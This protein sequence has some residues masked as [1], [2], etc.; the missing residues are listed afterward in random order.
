MVKLVTTRIS[1]AQ[2]KER[3]YPLAVL[4]IY[5]YCKRILDL[6]CSWTPSKKTV[7]IMVNLKMIQSCVF[8]VPIINN[9][10]YVITKSVKFYGAY[11]SNNILHVTSSICACPVNS[12]SHQ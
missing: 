3:N 2:A 8:D 9:Y 12:H 10:I 5:D 11:L 1:P 6:T 7:D 4:R